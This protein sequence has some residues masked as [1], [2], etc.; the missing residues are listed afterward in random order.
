DPD[1]VLAA[2]IDGSEKNRLE[3]EYNQALSDHREYITGYVTEN[4]K[5]FSIRHGLTLTEIRSRMVAQYYA[6]HV[7]EIEDAVRQIKRFHDAIKEME[8][9]ISKSYDLN[10]VFEEDATDFLIQ[11]FIDHSATTDEILSKI[12]TDFYDGFN[13]IR[14]RTGKSR[15][16]LSKNA[17]IDHETYLNDLIRN[18]LK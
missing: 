17:L 9:E 6:A 14:E 3:Q 16:F 5:V 15:F 12:Y 4:W 2:I 7:M 1:Q 10:V 18:E 11:Q 8:V 13:L